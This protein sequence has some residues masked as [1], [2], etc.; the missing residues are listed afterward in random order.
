M[1]HITKEQLEHLAKLSRVKLTSAEEEKLLPQLENIIWF[2]GQLQEIDLDE[3]GYATQETMQPREWVEDANMT[4]E[5]LVNVEH[6][7]IEKT[8]RIN[9]QLSEK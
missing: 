4:D 8:I 2:V 9:S 6:P 7:V 5:L 1:S 3:D